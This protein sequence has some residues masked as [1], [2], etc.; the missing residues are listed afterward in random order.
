MAIWNAS[1]HTKRRGAEPV[2]AVRDKVRRDVSAPTVA[3]KG[4]ESRGNVSGRPAIQILPKQSCAVARSLQSDSKRPVVHAP[5]IDVHAILCRVS[6]RIGF[7]DGEVVQVSASQHFGPGWA[8]DWRMGEEMS[9]SGPGVSDELPSTRHGG[10]D[11]VCARH[12]SS[13][14]HLILIVSQDENNVPASDVRGLSG[15]S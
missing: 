12:E 5:A 4:V 2:H 3:K 14:E 13:A 8:A 7:V 6:G 9:G 10:G 15:G 1:R 11:A